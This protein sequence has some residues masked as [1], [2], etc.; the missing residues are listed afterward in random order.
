MKK[1]G[2]SNMIIADGILKQ[3]EPS[4]RVE[5][6]GVFKEVWV[7]PIKGDIFIPRGVKVIGGEKLESDHDRFTV[8]IFY[9]PFMSNLEVR[10]VKM[11]DEVEVIGAKAFEHCSNLESITFSSNLKSIHINAFL[12]CTSLGEV[13][14][15]QSV[16]YIHEWAFSHC[17]Y[18]V[19]HVYQGSEGERYANENHIPFI[20]VNPI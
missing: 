14:I 12:G 13:L 2:G 20:L 16:E 19:L 9:A 1:N 7:K 18:L 11:S 8:D 15:P 4:K 6:V 10:S 17:P 5:S 3:W